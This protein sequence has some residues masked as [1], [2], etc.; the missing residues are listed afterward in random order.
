MSELVEVFGLK[1]V[2]AVVVG[3]WLF[4]LFITYWYIKTTKDQYK[5]SLKINE[6]LMKIIANNTKALTKLG[7]LIDARTRKFI[8]KDDE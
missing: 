6:R 5:A 4:A 3:G 1:P 2:V 8:G 7:A